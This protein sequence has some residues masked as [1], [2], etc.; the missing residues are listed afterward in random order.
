MVQVNACQRYK[1]YDKEDDD[2][3][4]RGDRK[5]IDIKPGTDQDHR[6][7]PGEEGIVRS[8]R[9]PSF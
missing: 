2:Q 9:S 6:A 8:P 4:G 3:P 7:D 1:Q 5:W